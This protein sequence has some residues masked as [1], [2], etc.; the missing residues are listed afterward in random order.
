MTKKT[1]IYSFCIFWVLIFISHSCYYDNAEELYGV[2]D[3]DLTEVG[4]DVDVEPLLRL[5][6]YECHDNASRLGGITLEGYNNVLP[7]VNNA[8]LLGS[9]KHQSGYS[10]M[11]QDQPK[12]PECD[13]VIIEQWIEEGAQDN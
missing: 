9:V 13:I 4:Y 8:S 11:P 7:Y 1:F 10:P 6:C 3:C 5:F 2:P 12:I